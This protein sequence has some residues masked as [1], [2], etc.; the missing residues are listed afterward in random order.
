MRVISVVDDDPSVRWATVNLLDSAGLAC[1]AFAS[2]EEYLASEWLACTSCLILDVSMPG[3]S[4][5]ELHHKL[6]RSGHSIPVIF[7][8]AFPKE[9]VRVQIADCGVIC[10]LL[11][12][13][14]DHELLGCIRMALGEPQPE[15]G[16]ST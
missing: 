16:S 5:M 11:K 1:Q 12:P 14:N 6:V 3:L 2:A 13:Y 7:I 4:G 10:C 8:T 9:R 15:F